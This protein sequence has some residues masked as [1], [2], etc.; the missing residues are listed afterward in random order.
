MR[1][2]SPR[3]LG[4]ILVALGSALA[5]PA[6]AG[7]WDVVGCSDRD[8]FARGWAYLA[9][10]DEGPNCEFLW[11]MRNSIFAEHGYCFHT[12]RG[13]AMFGGPCR[14]GDT[15]ALGLS[16]IERANIETI[17]TA[18]RVKRCPR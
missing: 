10:P 12:A 7:C 8:D 14:T 13:R 6:G 1:P 18:E 4:P 17:A 5:A 9:S 3:I 16:R 2:L 11:Q 15:D